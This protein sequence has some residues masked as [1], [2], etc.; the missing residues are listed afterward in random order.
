MRITAPRFALRRARRPQRGGVCNCRLRV[1][2]P[3]RPAFVIG[4]SCGAGRGLKR[5]AEGQLTGLSS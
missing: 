5:I 4:R 1:A 2:F 3:A